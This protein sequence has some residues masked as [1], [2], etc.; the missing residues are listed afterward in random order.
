MKNRYLNTIQNNIG[1]ILGMVITAFITGCNDDFFNKQPLDQASDATFWQSESDAKLA[2]VGCYYTEAGWRGEDFW[3]PRSLLYL[4]LMAGNGSEKELIP[5]HVTDGTLTSAYWVTEGYWDHSYAKIATCNNFLDHIQKISL[6]EDTKAMM[7]AEVRTLRAYEYFNLALYFGDVPLVTNLLTIVQANSVSRTSKSEVWAFVENELK[8]SVPALP[9]SRP[10]SEN[11]RITSAAA[12]AILGR[13]QLALKDWDN[14]A[15]SYKKIIDM[16]YYRIDPKFRELFFE[17][18]ELS[19]EFI[20]AS[21]YQKDVYGHVLLTYMLPESWGG[22]HQFSPYNE[23]V[24]E[25]ECIDGKP[26][27]ESPL[28]DPKN[29]Y[30]NRDPRLDATIMINERTVFRGKT[31]VSTPGSSSPDRKD[32]YPVWSGY[33]ILKFLED[34]ETKNQWS[35]GGNFPIIRYAEVLLGYLEA[36][37]ESGAGID[38]ALLDQTIN[39]VRSREAVKMPPISTTDP[40]SLRTIIRRER[41][42]EFAFE[43]I[44]YFDILRWGIAAQELNKQFTGMKLTN[45]PANYSDYPVDSDGYFIVGNR[46]FKEGINELWPIPQS[47]RDVN[48]NLTQNSG[49]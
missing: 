45:D 14:A 2:L 29:P 47:E 24:K 21:Q 48:P 16:G 27:D 43:G 15:E 41:R 44:R 9:N 39:L 20:L 42:V 19:K 25:F 26:I 12:L 33:C 46:N 23:L 17:E 7:I 34:D 10:D 35:Y 38:Q 4:D 22:W 18:N 49:Y 13:L 31:F 30:D 37:L 11:G 36:K 3:T 40:S 32:K 8:E 5:D 28:F 1:I 6:E